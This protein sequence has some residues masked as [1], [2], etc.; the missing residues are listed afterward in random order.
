MQGAW[1]SLGS[2]LGPHIRQLCLAQIQ[3]ALDSAPCFVFQLT[4]SIQLINLLTFGF[5]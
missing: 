4:A 3:F 1:S 5:D 2:P